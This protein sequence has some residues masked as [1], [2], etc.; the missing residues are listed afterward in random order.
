MVFLFINLYIL[1][2]SGTTDN[3]ILTTYSYMQRNMG[4]YEILSDENK[5]LQIIEGLEENED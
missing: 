1:K 3:C 5:P 4:G 2:V